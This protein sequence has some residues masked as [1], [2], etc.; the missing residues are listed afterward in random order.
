MRWPWV[1][2]WEVEI[3]EQSSHA[4]SR[5]CEGLLDLIRR[6]DGIIEDAAPDELENGWCLDCGEDFRYDDT[7]GYNPPCSCG[8]HCRS[9][10]D[11]EEREND[12]WMDAFAD[13]AEESDDQTR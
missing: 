9:C 12:E 3:W 8:A 10:H 7:G 2:R 11:A 1:W 6:R 13:E 5:Q 4:W